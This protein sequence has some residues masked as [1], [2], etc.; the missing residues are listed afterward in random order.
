MTIQEVKEKLKTAKNP[1]ARSLHQGA[2]FKVLVMGFNKGMILKKHQAHIK[3]KLT[4]MEGAVTYKEANRLVILDQ[5]AEVD[6]PTNV[7]H[8]VEATE[9]SLC[10]LTQGE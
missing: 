6:I 5:Y 1:V 2:G 8:S 7:I 3:A 9:D 4:V 10:I